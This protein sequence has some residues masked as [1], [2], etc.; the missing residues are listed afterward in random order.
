MRYITKLSIALGLTLLLACVQLGVAAS[1][2]KDVKI[3]G[4]SFTWLLGD[5]K[6]RQ[7]A[8]DFSEDNPPKIDERDTLTSYW[9]LIVTA[10]LLGPSDG[11]SAILYFAPE[12]KE[13]KGPSLYMKKVGDRLEA[14]LVTYLCS[15]VVN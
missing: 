11:I 8:Y 4:V 15:A 10:E 14:K 9:T 5:K 3:G 1:G 6:H 13:L 7:I 2:V 12:D